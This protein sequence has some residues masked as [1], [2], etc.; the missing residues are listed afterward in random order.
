VVIFW[1]THRLIALGAVTGLFILIGSV[2]LW[3]VLKALKAM[4]ATFEASLA[5]LAKDYKQLKS[6]D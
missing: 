3:R 1:D 6:N 5:E 4:P 2:Y